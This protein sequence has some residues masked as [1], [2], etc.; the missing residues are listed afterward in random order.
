M[1]IS[2][3]KD[4]FFLFAALLSYLAGALLTRFQTRSFNPVNFLLGIAIF[5]L[6]YALKSLLEYLTTS[7]INP[8]T[9]VNFD[10]QDKKYQL[11][12]ATIILFTGAFTVGYLLLQR[13]ILIGVNLVYIVLILF[14][15]LLPASRFGKL[16]QT[17][18]SII[19]EALTGSLLM[20]LLG[21][22]VQSRNPTPDDFLIALPLFF[23]F[24]ASSIAYQFPDFGK[25]ISKRGKGF[26]D[27]IGW[28]NGIKLHNIAILAAYLTLIVFLTTRNTFYI[29]WPAL[30]TIFISLFEIFLLTRVVA[31]IKP[32]WGMLRTTAFLQYFSIVYFL[33]F[34]IL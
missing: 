15:F 6:G 3:K 24:I 16:V 8:Y 9:R 13:N 21:I 12:L 30:L 4:A 33:V 29:Y 2:L 18:Y 19:I 17:N 32:N 14:L 1:S 26:L 20:F 10:R 22:G 27:L 5:L 28:E 34:P 25:E 7:R 23:L 31:G 11:L